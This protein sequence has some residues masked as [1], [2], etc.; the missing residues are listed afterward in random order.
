M[1]SELDARLKDY[2]WLASG[3]FSLAD[4]AWCIDIQRFQLMKCPMA[5]PALLGWYGKIEAQPSL[6]KMV[7]DYEAEVPPRF[8]A[9]Q[10]MGTDGA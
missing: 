9:P 5:H 6:K 3:A 8:T 10:R 7:L 1:L 4:I 2:E